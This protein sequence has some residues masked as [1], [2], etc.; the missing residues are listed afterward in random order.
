MTKRQKHEY[1]TSK[2]VADQRENAFVDDVQKMENEKKIDNVSE[3]SKVPEQRSLR[4]KQRQNYEEMNDE[5]F[6]SLLLKPK[7]VVVQR[8]ASG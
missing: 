5:D 7:T 3:V 6:N 2:K 1:R 8:R 4:F